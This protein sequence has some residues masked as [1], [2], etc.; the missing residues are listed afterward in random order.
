MKLREGDTLQIEVS[1]TKQIKTHV[2]VIQDPRIWAADFL[3]DIWSENWRSKVFDVRFLRGGAV[4]SFLVEIEGRDKIEG[5]GLT[6]LLRVS[7]VEEVQR[8]ASYRLQYSFNV[9]MRYKNI[10][11]DEEE[12]FEKCKGF[13]ISETGIGL[14]SQGTW[15]EGDEV[16]CK[17]EINN[18]QFEFEAT[19]MRRLIWSKEDTYYY[20]LGI[21]F[22]ADDEAQLKNIRRFIFK[23]QIKHSR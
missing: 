14:T 9:Y 11:E 7:E 6:R 19:I 5:I 1:D 22:K 2:E 21:K 4:Y 20:K 23:E 13:D 16:I 3:P 12:Q 8:R 15:K 17:F 18:Q 10:D